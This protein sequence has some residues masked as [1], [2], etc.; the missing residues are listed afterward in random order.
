[1]FDSPRPASAA[2]PRRSQQKAT[3]ARED[4]NLAVGNA[5][6][7]GAA[8]GIHTIDNSTVLRIELESGQPTTP[9]PSSATTTTASPATKSITTL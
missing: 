5:L 6:N 8:K 3:L 7:G 2:V 1:L 4:W 9:R